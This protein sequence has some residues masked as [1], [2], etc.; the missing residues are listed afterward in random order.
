M[1]RAYDNNVDLQTP[2]VGIEVER[3]S[4]YGM[5]ITVVGVPRNAPNF[6]QQSFEARC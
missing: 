2:F 5:K 4:C 3:T 1:K 6:Y